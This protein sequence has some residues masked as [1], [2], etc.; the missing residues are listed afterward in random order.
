MLEFGFVDGFG[1]WSG[2]RFFVFV[3]FWIR[4][5][6]VFRFGFFV[7]KRS[8]FAS[9]VCWAKFF[10]SFEL[11]RGLF[12]VGDVAGRRFG[13]VFVVFS[14]FECYVIGRVLGWFFGGRGR[15]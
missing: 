2:I 15:V 9:F 1:F 4:G 8:W 7:R 11:V 10:F 13:S 3:V 6:V 5:L 12:L 14:E